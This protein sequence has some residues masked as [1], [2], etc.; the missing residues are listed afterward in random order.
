MCEACQRTD[1]TQ[2]SPVNGSNISQTQTQPDL[3]ARLDAILF[4]EQTK[5]LL[6][7]VR[8]FQ[9]LVW[10]AIAGAVAWWG[11]AY[12]PQLDIADLLGES[13]E[14]QQSIAQIDSP[15]PVELLP[16]TGD[17][18][19]VYVP[20]ET[21]VQFGGDVSEL[22]SAPNKSAYLDFGDNTEWI[23]LGAWPELP[24]HVLAVPRELSAIVLG[25]EVVIL[26]GEGSDQEVLR[27]SFR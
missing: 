22:D 6:G 2:T 15:D 21:Q 4:P 8:F 13:S 10:V 5:S 7:R 11:Y 3:L 18:F 24:P 26:G 19:A 23:E 12:W 1:R 9:T 25:A 16:T 27:I 17:L 14:P 20:T